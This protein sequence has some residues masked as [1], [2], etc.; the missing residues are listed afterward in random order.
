MRNKSLVRA[1]LSTSLAKPGANTQVNM[2]AAATA[3]IV[4][5]AKMAS[6]VPDT[7][8]TK[9]LMSFS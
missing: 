2:G 9:P 5:G 1:N 6:K 3:A 8:F 4:N 7:P